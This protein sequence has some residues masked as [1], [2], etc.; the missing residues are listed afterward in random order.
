M[1]LTILATALSLIAAAPAAIA[2]EHDKLRHTPAQTGHAERSE[3][4]DAVF[5]ASER[6][7]LCDYFR[8]ISCGTA[9][10]LGDG[11][12]KI[13]GKVGS[14]DKTALPP[15]GLARHDDLPPGLEKQYQR[16]GKLPPGLQ[17]RQLPDDLRLLLPRRDANY[18][19]VIVGDDVVLVQ[20]ATG[21]ILDLLEGIAAGR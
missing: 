15:P 13:K 7:V 11:K 16:N 12:G 19:R 14:R 1:R 2:Q 20:I 3:I 17:K 5:T 6:R 4:A 18:E 9:N 10:Q 8:I 21:V